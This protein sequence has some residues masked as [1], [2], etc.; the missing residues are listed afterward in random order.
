MNESH[1]TD[2]HPAHADCLLFVGFLLV[3]QD[4]EGRGGASE[5]RTDGGCSDLAV[6]VMVV[7]MV[8]VVVVVVVVL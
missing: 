2:I 6:M 8:V 7:V 1:D 4:G 3:G 5:V